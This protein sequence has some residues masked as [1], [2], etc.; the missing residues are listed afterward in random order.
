M[1][2]PRVREPDNLSTMG[3]ACAVKISQTSW[4]ERPRYIWKGSK[5]THL[6][7]NCEEFD[8]LDREMQIEHRGLFEENPAKKVAAVKTVVD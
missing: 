4:D 5:T 6:I 2:N 8:F 3:P 1:M 7:G